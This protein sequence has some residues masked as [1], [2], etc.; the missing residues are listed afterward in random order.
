MAPPIGHLICHFSLDIYKIEAARQVDII[1]LR[2]RIKILLKTWQL[3]H[4]E[5]IA[6]LNTL[7]VSCRLLD[8]ILL[9]RNTL[10]VARRIAIFLERVVLDKV[11]I[12]VLS[13]I[14][15]NLGID[16]FFR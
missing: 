6:C 13:V 7:S 10:V 8:V 15:F 4:H 5:D 9:D 1:Q 11:R 3:L 12:M 14:F 2:L 16:L